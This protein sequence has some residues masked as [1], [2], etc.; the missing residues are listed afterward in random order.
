MQSPRQLIP[1]RAL[2]GHD[3][4]RLRMTLRVALRRRAARIDRILG[5]LNDTLTV[6]AVGL[7]LLAVVVYWCS[8]PGLR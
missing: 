6:Y 8:G 1:F 7:A 5:Q 2:L 3:I 4:S